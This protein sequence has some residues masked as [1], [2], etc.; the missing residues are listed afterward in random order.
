MWPKVAEGKESPQS[1][2]APVHAAVNAGIGSQ[3]L[4]VAPVVTN[5]ANS[6]SQ[7]PQS[8]AISAG[9]RIRGEFTGHS[10]LLIDG[11]VQ[12][13]IRLPKSKVTVG[14]HGSVQADIEAREIVIEG[15][16]RG[17]L[18]AS[19]NVRLGPKSDV[20]G[21]MLTPRVAIEDG[22]RLRGKVEMVRPGEAK[23]GAAAGQG[24]TGV[25]STSI[26]SAK[27]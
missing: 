25:V 21:S 7:I 4:A 15:K 2:P 17:N 12:G 27:E 22:A 5:S 24:K 18:N 11:E 20:Q 13:S 10:D 1:S 14:P 3:P 8:S 9:L 19:E 6:S 26:A 16:I 23:R